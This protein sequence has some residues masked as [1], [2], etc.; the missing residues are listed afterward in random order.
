MAGGGGTRFWPVSRMTT[1]KQ[2][3]RLTGSDV[4][5]NETIKH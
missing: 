2:L 3:A 1:P 4:M 5:I